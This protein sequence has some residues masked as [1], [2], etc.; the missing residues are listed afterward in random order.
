MIASFCTAAVFMT[1]WTNASRSVGGESL[2]RHS[3][4]ILLEEVGYLVLHQTQ[5]VHNL[6]GVLRLLDLEELGGL[7]CE[8]G[9]VVD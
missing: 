5:H 1:C 3:I 9:V 7:V 6:V 8:R 4:K 2:L